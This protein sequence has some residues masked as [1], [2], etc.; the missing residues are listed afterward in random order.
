MKTVMTLKEGIQGKIVRNSTYKVKDMN[1]PHS[2]I[3]TSSHD[4]IKAERVNDKQL[5]EEEKCGNES[6]K[7]KSQKTSL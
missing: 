7:H 3:T 1:T 2:D 6:K 5:R 4:M